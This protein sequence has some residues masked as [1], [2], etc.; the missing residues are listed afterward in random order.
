MI[1]TCAFC[2]RPEL[3]ANIFTGQSNSFKGSTP[4]SLQLCF[5][6]FI[7]A[8]LVHFFLPAVGY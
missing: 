6:Y 2:L 7:S 1:M 4:A 8:Q 3:C 5:K